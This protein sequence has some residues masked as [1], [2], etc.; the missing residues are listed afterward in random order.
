MVRCPKCNSIHVS[1]ILYGM[2]TYEAFEMADR[3]ELILGGCEVWDNQPN[4]G[5]L[6]CKFQ[7]SKVS[8]PASAIK[9]LRFKVWENGPGF[10][11]IMKTWVYE[12]HRDGKVVKYTYYGKNRKYTEKRESSISERKLMKLYHEIQKVVSSN[13]ED[14]IVSRV[15]DGSSY[16]LQVSYIDGQKEILNGDI[17]GGAIDKILVEFI[18]MEFAEEF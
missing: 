11:D 13:D 16:Q 3:G 15:C 6:N 5:C 1:K 8:L 9:K 18:C 12:I 17:N 4:Y 14:I 7:W 10:L 2:P